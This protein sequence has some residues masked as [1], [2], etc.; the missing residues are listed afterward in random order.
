MAVTPERTRMRQVQGKPL[1]LGVTAEKERVN[2]A[3]AAEE[4]KECKLLLYPSGSRK[5]CESYSMAETVGEVRY[6]A[7]EEMDTA[8]YEYN[9]EIDG[10]I[11]IDPYVKAIAGKTR[12][13]ENKSPEKHE[14]RGVLDT[15]PYDWE[16]D[17][18]PY[19]PYCD[20]VAYSLHV[21]GFTKDSSLEPK[22][23]G[24]FE[25]IIEKI[26]YLKDLGVNQLHL[27]PVYEFEECGAY[28]NYWGYGMAY[29][30]APK[31]GYSAVGD[32]VRSLKD[33]I[34]ACHREGMEVVLEMPFSA[35]VS[36]QYMEECLR[37]YLMEYHV[38]G[39]I[40][41]PGTTPLDAVCQ[42]PILKKTKIL[43]HRIDFQNVMR[44]FLKGDG[45]MI[46]EVINWLR[47]ISSEEGI[48]N[49]ITNQS[50]FTLI[51]LV[52]YNEKHNEDNGEDNRDGSDY[53]LSW[54][55]G[56]EGPSRKKA[57]VEIR[58]RQVRNAYFLTLLAQG[59]PC[60][61]AGDEFGNTQ[62][63]NNNVYCQDNPVGWVNWK[64]YEKKKELHDFV[65]KLIQIRK[66][67][68]VFCPQ[69]AMQGAD[70]VGCG[71]PDVSYHGEEAWMTPSEHS[72][73]QLGVYYHDE[74]GTDCFVAYNMHWLEHTFALP[75]LLKNK[76]WHLLIS[77]DEENEKCLEDQKLIELPPRTI[78]VFVGRDQDED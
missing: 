24:T 77:T 29:F 9:Y 65:K 21:R 61:L 28:R 47:H 1:P 64:K 6:L 27:M 60:I 17:R 68:K 54:N 34:K 30:F 46:P 55:G 4:G 32:G 41:N 75:L 42:D 67:Y 52:S 58:R 56:A 31:N 44:K 14:V 2:F 53:N 35:Q 38:D 3:V 51:D 7:F 66:Q 22:I 16:D 26:P 62:K 39:F 71:I 18:H 5:P 11:T 40:L 12:W 8:E 63:G 10:E 57:V 69:R 23:R 72:S 49:Y 76:K 70:R 36:K 78:A 20:I 48:F 59:T 15:A 37:Y 45:G 43:H 13:G 73:R 74:D 50:G 33:M 19:L 25:G